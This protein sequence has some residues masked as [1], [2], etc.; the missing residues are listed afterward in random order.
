MGLWLY[1][2]SWLPKPN[3]KLFCCR[4][5]NKLAKDGK[6]VCESPTTSMEWS[7][8]PA[9]G[10]KSDCL[11]KLEGGATASDMISDDSAFRSPV[12]SET[13]DINVI[14]QYYSF[15]K[16]KILNR[17]GANIGIKKKNKNNKRK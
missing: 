8:W 11:Y 16:S 13:S 4:G 5:S 7:A 9:A 6:K 15:I 14:K 2:P 3:L 1:A 12:S 17:I 10:I